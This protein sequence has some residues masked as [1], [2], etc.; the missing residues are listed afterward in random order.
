[1]AALQKDHLNPYFNLTKKQKDEVCDLTIMLDEFWMTKL[2][3]IIDYTNKSI[4]ELSCSTVNAKIKSDRV[5]IS[6]YDKFIKKC[7]KIMSETNK[8]HILSELI[9]ISFKMLKIKN[10][11]AARCNFLEASISQ[12]IFDYRQFTLFCD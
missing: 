1:M 10:T 12:N 2:Q 3:P 11:I 4:L 7:E 6:S 9:V 8:I 5:L